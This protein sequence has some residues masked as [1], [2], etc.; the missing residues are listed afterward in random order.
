MNTEQTDPDKP[1]AVPL[2][3]GLTRPRM[4]WGIPWGL[5]VAEIVLVLMIF[6]NTK[7][8]L[9]FLLILPMHAASYVLTIKDAR[10]VDI[11]R[12]RLLKCAGTR[13]ARFWGGNSYTH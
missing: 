1:Q 5:F 2:V 9:M 8:L 4:L 7:N 13:N 11:I 6:L 10:L 3:L 12:V